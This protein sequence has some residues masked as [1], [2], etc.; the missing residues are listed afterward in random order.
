MT[1]TCCRRA[2]STGSATAGPTRRRLPPVAAWRS[3]R[4]RS[5]IV[6]SNRMYIVMLMIVGLTGSP[7]GV[8]IT[9]KMTMARMA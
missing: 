6:I 7:P 1:A 4:A 2:G 5:W 3:E 8:M 9:A